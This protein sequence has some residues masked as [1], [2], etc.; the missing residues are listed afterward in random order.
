MSDI[1]RFADD[2]VK[3]HAGARIVI[4]A[5]RAACMTRA[6][7]SILKKLVADRDPAIQLTWHCI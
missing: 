2:L 1:E 7:F 4:V 5:D 3:E 6:E